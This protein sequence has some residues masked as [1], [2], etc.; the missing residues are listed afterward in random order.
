MTKAMTLVLNIRMLNTCYYRA[1][2]NSCK[3]YDPKLKCNLLTLGDD[4]YILYIKKTMVMM[5]K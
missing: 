4:G 2:C 5:L 1:S 3:L